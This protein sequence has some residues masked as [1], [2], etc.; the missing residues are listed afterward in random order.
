[1]QAQ[2]SVFHAEAA[3]QRY[4]AGVEHQAVQFVGAHSQQFNNLL[5]EL[6]AARSVLTERDEAVRR[7]KYWV[8]VCHEHSSWSSRK[9]HPLILPMPTN[10]KALPLQDAS[11]L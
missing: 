8:V 9:R 1:M 6:Q 10:T 3:A 7:L 2:Q 4:A 5:G 11:E